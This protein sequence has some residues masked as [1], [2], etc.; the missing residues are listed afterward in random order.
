[1][2]VFKSANSFYTNPARADLYSINSSWGILFL[3]NLDRDKRYLTIISYQEAI[4]GLM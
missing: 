1:M 2:V 4:S 3:Q